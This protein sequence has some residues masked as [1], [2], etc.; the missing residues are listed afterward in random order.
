MHPLA[1]IADEP[2]ALTVFLHAAK[3]A[4]GVS[5]AMRAGEEFGGGLMVHRLSSRATLVPPLAL[6]I[7]GL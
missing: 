5:V 4:K 1:V 2:L 6:E 7:V 3:K